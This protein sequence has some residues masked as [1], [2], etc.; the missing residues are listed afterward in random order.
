MPDGKDK[1]WQ[2]GVDSGALLATIII[3]LPMLLAVA[4]AGAA[5]C[6]GL[7]LFLTFINNR[8]TVYVSETKYYIQFAEGRYEARDY[9]NAFT[10][11]DVIATEILGRVMEL[12]GD[13]YER[14]QVKEMVTADI[15]S[16]V[17][18]LTVT[19]KGEDAQQVERI[20]DALCTA[21][22]EFP[23]YKKEFDSIYQIEDLEIVPEQV[24]YFAWR[25]ALLGA[26]LFAGAGFF[27]VCLRFSVGSAFY[28]KTDIEKA[29]GVPVY[30][31]TFAG[32]GQ[33][34][35]IKRQK[36]MLA[37]GI[38]LLASRN[39]QLWLLDAFDGQ[40]AEAVLQKLQAEYVKIKCYSTSH[41]D[42]ETAVVLV[43]PFGVHCREKMADEMRNAQLHGGKIVGAL[44]VNVDN[45]WA[46]LYYGGDRFIRKGK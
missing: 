27:H 31:M 45:L 21:L 36:Q 38:Q 42:R 26:V 46:K 20:K 7:H 22:E 41:N 39:P 11:N 9:Y 25:A 4:I 37:D 13:G 16:D 5:I 40:E 34:A 24:N 23:S 2:E 1:L 35:L 14:E 32:E 43:I 19:V 18:Y 28:T 17:R 33:S 12:L 30:G 8:S 15:L 44:L 29:F 3:K 10:W 6:S